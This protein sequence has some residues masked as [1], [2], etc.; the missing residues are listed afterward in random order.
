MSRESRKC[1]F[2]CLQ[3]HCYSNFK[4]GQRKEIMMSILRMRESINKCKC[5]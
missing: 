1:H 5:Y 3:C 4:G 2:L